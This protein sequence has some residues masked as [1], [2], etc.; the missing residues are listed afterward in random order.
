MTP[1]FEKSLVL[2]G[3]GEREDKMKVEI[4]HFHFRR[5][6]KNVGGEIQRIHGLG[7]TRLR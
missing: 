7:K 5:R 4:F 3:G 2:G 6:S 1:K